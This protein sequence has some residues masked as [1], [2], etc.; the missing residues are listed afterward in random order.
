VSIFAMSQGDK[1]W[2]NCPCVLPISPCL[3]HQLYR[4]ISPYVWLLLSCCLCYCT[5]HTWITYIIRWWDEG[6]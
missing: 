4:W 6:K 2:W 5:I 1:K 3:I